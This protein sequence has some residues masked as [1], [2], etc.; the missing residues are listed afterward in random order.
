[1]TAF[2][3][4]TEPDSERT[5][6][7]AVWAWRLASFS[8]PLLIVGLITQRRG[9]ADALAATS[10]YGVSFLLALLAIVLAIA[11]FV[12]IWNQGGRGLARAILALLVASAISTI[13][14]AAGIQIWRLPAINDIVTDPDFA[15]PFGALAE[16]HAEV[17]APVAYDDVNVWLQQLEA[18][19]QVVPLRFDD[20]LS[21][22]LDVVSK[23]I[24]RSGWRIVLTQE[25]QENGANFVIIEAIAPTPVFSYRDDVAIRLTESGEF[26]RIDMRSA[27]RFGAHD[28]GTNARRIVNFLQ[29]IE[30]AV[31]ERARV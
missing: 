8:V 26:V 1:M 28:L 27:S 18:Y 4:R 3:I 9:F 17:G 2:G 10:V 11:A 7:S 5:S 6:R 24:R 15:P 23:E 30:K 19:P 13:P 22:I 20:Q 29:R 14:I 31:K 16:Q 21:V 12:S 25:N